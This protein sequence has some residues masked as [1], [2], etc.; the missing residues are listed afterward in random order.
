LPQT[1]E[2]VAAMFETMDESTLANIVK[3]SPVRA[4]AVLAIFAPDIED[5]DVVRLVRLVAALVRM[6][7]P[8]DGKGK[9]ENRRL[10]ISE[11]KAKK[12]NRQGLILH[13]TLGLAIPYS[14]PV[15][16]WPT[17]PANLPCVF[18]CMCMSWP[19]FRV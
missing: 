7:V 9:K 13:A 1:L 19:V 17:P 4:D 18:F 10:M 15:N 11:N 12:E 2:L 8:S 6:F 14:L 3:E 5:A 16:Y